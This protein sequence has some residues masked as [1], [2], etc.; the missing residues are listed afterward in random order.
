MPLPAVFDSDARV[1]MTVYWARADFRP[2]LDTFCHGGGYYTTGGK[3]L[4][5]EISDEL[6]DKPWI[7]RKLPGEPR[8][9][10]LNPL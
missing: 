3:Y 7:S 2:F 6:A 1:R 10:L 4:C 8:I 5:Y 9:S